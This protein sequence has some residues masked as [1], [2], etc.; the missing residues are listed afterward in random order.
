MNDLVA[1]SSLTFEDSVS[2]CSEKLPILESLSVGIGDII[3]FN[4]NNKT[5]I[6]E[7]SNVSVSNI[8]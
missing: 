2:F 5:L 8:I 6:K 7:F 3:T 4:F 1:E